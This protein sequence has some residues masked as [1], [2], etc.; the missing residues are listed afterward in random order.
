ML[1]LELLDPPCDKPLQFLVLA[2]K[3]GGKR[4]LARGKVLLLDVEANAALHQEGFGSS[5]LPGSLL[6]R[7]VKVRPL[8]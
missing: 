1:L 3:L 7:L 2:A 5:S 4:R 8:Q 6:L